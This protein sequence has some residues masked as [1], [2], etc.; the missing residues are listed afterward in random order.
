LADWILSHFAAHDCYV[1]PFA[2]G[3]SVLLSKDPARHEVYNDLDK[4]VVNFFE[5]LRTRTTELVQAIEWTPYSREELRRAFEPCND[6]LES[7][8]RLY[9]RNWQGY[10][11]LGRNSGWRFCKTGR[12]SAVRQWTRTEHL[13]A[14]AARL[15]E[16][17]IE[18]DKASAVIARFDTPDTLFYVDPPYLHETRNE[19][20]DD[21]YAHEM[22]DD[23]HRA[24][25][26]QLRSLNGMMILSGYPSAL[27]DELYFDWQYVEHQSLDLTGQARTERLWISPSLM[28][29]RIQNAQQMT[30]L[31]MFESE[32]D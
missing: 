8:R 17:Q 30:T 14:V 6:P 15:K 31:P 26:A 21:A 5:V 20:N 2:G 27:Y 12:A 11:V 24:L 18:C 10:G 16:V 3:A 29:R 9:V 25:A 7:A 22:T 13:Y 23:E 19:R 4:R 28:A 32:V 1:E